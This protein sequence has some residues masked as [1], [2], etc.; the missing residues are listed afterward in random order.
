MAKWHKRGRLRPATATF[1]SRQRT[2]RMRILKRN[3][4]R[5][6]ETPKVEM[7]DVLVRTL[8]RSCYHRISNRRYQRR[9][10]E[11][12]F[13]RAT[14][15]QTVRGLW[16]SAFRHWL[17]RG[18]YCAINIAVTTSSVVVTTTDVS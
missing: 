6:V 8:D 9:G 18:Q 12:S 17:A 3:G 4:R 7:D 14:G 15:R 11:Y 2:T 10:T 16:P 5:F 1:D 13:Q